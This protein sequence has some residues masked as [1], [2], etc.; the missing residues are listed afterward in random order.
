MLKALFKKKKK[1]NFVQ[2]LT[3][4]WITKKKKKKIKSL[5]KSGFRT[6]SL[7]DGMR[8]YKVQSQIFSF[9][10]SDSSWD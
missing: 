6:L 7:I 9:H 1:E 4:D 10:Y 3:G 5:K 8:K 2:E